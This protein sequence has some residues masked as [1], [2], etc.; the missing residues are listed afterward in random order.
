MSRPCSER[1]FGSALVCFLLLVVAPVTMVVAV[2]YLL[3]AVCWI[4]NQEKERRYYGMCKVYKNRSA[5]S[6]VERRLSYHK[7]HPVSWMKHSLPETMKITPLGHCMSL[8]NALAEEAVRTASAFVD[9]GS[10]VRGGPWSGPHVGSVGRSDMTTVRRLA[11]R[12]TNSAEARAHVLAHA[13]G[14]PEDNSLRRHCE[15]LAFGRDTAPLG[16]ARK[17][18]WT[19]RSKCPSGCEKRKRKGWQPG[20]WAW[21]DHKWGSDVAANRQRNNAKR[22]RRR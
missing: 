19:R 20:D 18:K 8:E 11:S 5:E 14:L 4:E 12:A 2:V 6:A 16:P 13:E 22:D 15:N 10:D 9:G 21:A 17:A 1:E 7:S 3:T